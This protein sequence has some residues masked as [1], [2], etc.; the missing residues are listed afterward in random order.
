[1]F[2][3]TTTN[4]PMDFTFV[5]LQNSGTLDLRA[6]EIFFKANPHTLGNGSRVTGTGAVHVAGATVNV[7]GNIALDSPLALDTGVLGGSATLN[8][9]F[10]FSGGQVTGDI[11]V[12]GSASWS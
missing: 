7:A 5:L 12:E 1:I 2:R 3:K 11:G 10:A 6:G 9:P 4:R 8:G